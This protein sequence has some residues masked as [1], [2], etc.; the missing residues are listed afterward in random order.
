MRAAVIENSEMS[1]DFDV[2]KGTKQGCVLAPL[3]FT[4]ISAMMLRVAFQHCEA[5][6]PIH[7]RMD[8]DVV[9]LWRLQARRKYN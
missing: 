1:S 7:Y 5:G 8:G 3:M 2:T 4:T 6:V 9:D